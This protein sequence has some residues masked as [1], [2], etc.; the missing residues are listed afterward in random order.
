MG[1]AATVIAAGTAISGHVEGAEDI[2]VFGRVEGSIRLE[3]ALVVDEKARLDAQ[4]DVTSV[5][6]SGIVVGN[7]TASELI[8]LTSSARVVG[9]MTAPRIIVE[10]GATYAGQIDTG[11]VESNPDAGRGR[12]AS[13]TRSAPSRPVPVRTAPA[14]TA[15]S[16]P[17]PSR[18]VA[19]SKPDPAP[20]E[21]PI[22][23]TEANSDEVAEPAE[24]SAP[25][26][27]ASKKSSTSKKSS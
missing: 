3:G 24:T 21:A 13:P 16:R 8:E 11:N 4:V 15:S 19:R 26:K 9:D 10:D 25:T 2:D 1:K 6:V 12:R 23:A 27:S 20:A 14:R 7:V 5:T 17:A 18:P 22:A